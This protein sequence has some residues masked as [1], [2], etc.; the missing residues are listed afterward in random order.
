[1]N[2]F[3]F[4]TGKR[5]ATTLIWIVS[6]GFF[7]YIT[8]A[9]FE[10]FQGAAFSDILDNFPEAFKRAFGLTHDLSTILG[11]FGLIGIYLFLAGAIFSSHLGLN[12]VSVEERDL[13]ADF[14]ISKPV[15]RNR[16]LT[17]KISAGLVHLV[18]FNIAMGLICWAGMESFGGGQDYS[19]K[20]FL[21]IMGGL[22]IFQLLFYA[23]G[24]IISVLL[25]RMDSPLPFSLGLSVGL[26]IM[27]SFESVIADTP[28]KY[29]VP[30]DY[31][32]LAY[33]IEN[34]AFKTYGLVV[35]L[36]VI[37]A[38]IVGGYILYNRRDIATAM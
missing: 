13:T 4:E 31:F 2:I 22:F 5:L 38:G 26:Y 17:A 12:A 7:I 9:F 1:M 35:S 3:K 23:I 34:E 20:A 36:A 25:K 14:L 18:I 21:L 11:F 19:M 16:I 27:Y 6:V 32:D 37:T 8:F 33:I 10:S 24:L 15:T 29:L 30:Y 28:L